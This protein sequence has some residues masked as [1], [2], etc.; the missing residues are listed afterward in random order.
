M[1]SKKTIKQA[2]NNFGL[3]KPE[4]QTGKQESNKKIIEM[5]EK[6]TLN[7]SLCTLE[8][9]EDALDKAKAPIQR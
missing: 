7:L 6:A 2:K 3:A 4:S 5:K 8:T 1:E 9:L